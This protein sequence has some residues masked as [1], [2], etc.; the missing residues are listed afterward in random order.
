MRKT[1]LAASL[2]FLAAIL[3][4]NTALFTTPIF[5]H[6]DYASNSL[7]I[8]EAKGFREL[9]GNYS[10]WGFH[11][12]GPAVFYVMALGEW[13]FHDV[14]RLVPAPLNGQ[15]LAI[16]LLNTV[17]FFATVRIFLSHSPSRAFVPLALAAVA[18]VGATVNHDL[19]A[20]VAV[21]FWMP[22][23]ALFPFLFFLTVCASV[24]A[25]EIRRLPLLAGA[26]MLLI[27]LH[28]AQ[29]MF[30]P[31]LG[32]AACVSS[33]RRR[34]AEPWRRP[35]LAAVGVVCVFLAPIALEIALYEPDNLDKVLAYT[36][37]HGGAQKSL[38]VAL[39]YFASFLAYLPTPESAKAGLSSLWTWFAR[40]HVALYWL[41]FAALA[42]LSWRRKTKPLCP[43][44]RL[45][46]LACGLASALFLFWGTRI[47][48]ELYNFNGYFIY[49]AQLM[50]WL[51]PAALLAQ[52]MP[53]RAAAAAWAAALAL[54]AIFSPLFRV[55]YPGI[56]ALPAI[57]AA[58]PSMAPGELRLAFPPDEAGNAA[59][60]AV[61]LVRQGKPFCVEPAWEFAFGRAHACRAVSMTQTLL[62]LAP[63]EC[64][65][66]CRMVFQQPGLAVALRPPAWRRLPF[67]FTAEDGADVKESF[68]PPENGRRWTQRTGTIRFALAKDFGGSESVR[69]RVEGST[70]PGRPATL[71]LNGHVA[72][73]L[74]HI[75][76]SAAEFVVKREWLF[77]G[78]ENRLVFDVP[79]AGPIH[80]DYRMLGFRFERLR[81]DAVE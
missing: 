2:A 48:G 3:L 39:W 71:L 42:T 11:H 24:A 21:G 29:C 31:L 80:P 58:V 10:R 5:E 68:H 6:T 17:L 79:N 33:F 49:S 70:A 65:P 8:S 54:L 63:R 73:A 20:S 50:L 18:V 59:G 52:S 12:P 46:A 38:A 22:Y 66:P 23:V 16:I 30:V 51:V 67:E 74:D 36:R 32:G 81:M 34:G 25:G 13:L 27:H 69:I 56:P 78:Q 43:F 64:R 57:A 37:V 77:P 1:V 40:P 35:A 26:G 4:V 60:V 75:W 14:M 45:A 61:Q 41:A 47:A 19:E 72:G 55:A 76:N 15:I 62:A 28:V 9:L 53:K 7:Q 44:L